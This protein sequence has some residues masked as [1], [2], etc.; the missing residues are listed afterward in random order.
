MVAHFKHGAESSLV[1]VTSLD[2]GQPV[3]NAQVAVRACTGKLLWQG[4]TDAM[5][6]ASIREE[7][8]HDGCPYSEG[9]FVSAR[10]GNDMTFTLSNWSEG[11]QS[12]RFNVPTEDLRADKTIA[13]TVFDRTLLRAGE[14]VH[15]KHFIRRRSADGVAYAAPQ[16]KDSKLVI[17]HQGSDQKYELPLAWAGGGVAESTWTIP[18]DAKQGTYEVMFDGRVGGS[19]RVEQFRV[20][21]MKALLQGPSAPVAVSYTHLTLPTSD[22]V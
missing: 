9:Y 1:W 11:I 7:L 19:F 13:A 15:M 5:G 8:F 18:A 2:K 10:S 17:L 20:P 14:T 6:V 21:T 4:K 3:P 22:L 16:G 12:W